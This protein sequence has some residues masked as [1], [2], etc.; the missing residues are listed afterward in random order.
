MPLYLHQACIVQATAEAK[1]LLYCMANLCNNSALAS[2]VLSCN[3]QSFH[4]CV[5]VQVTKRA[6]TT[7]DDYL[8]DLLRKSENRALEAEGQTRHYSQRVRALEWQKFQDKQS[9]SD[10]QQKHDSLAA[11]VSRIRQEKRQVE[12]RLHGTFTHVSSL[13]ERAARAEQSHAAELA[14]VISNLEL[15]KK[16]RLL[17]I[18]VCHI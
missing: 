8:H 6:R 16:V 13:E 4:Q 15:S 9:D 17:E 12:E 1:P 2:T 7:T 14:D 5:C 18:N 10:L 3:Q 11:L